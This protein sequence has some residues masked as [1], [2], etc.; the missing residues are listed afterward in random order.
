[1]MSQGCGPH[2]LSDFRRRLFPH[3]CL[4]SS[5]PSGFMSEPGIVEWP[6]TK[7]FQSS[8]KGANPVI[9]KAC[10][11]SCSI[12]T[13]RS[14]VERHPLNGASVRSTTP[15]L[16]GISNS[17]SSSFCLKGKNISIN[18][19]CSGVFLRRSAPKSI[20]L[21]EAGCE[22]YKGRDFAEAD[23]P[24]P[25]WLSFICFF[26]DQ[27][28]FVLGTVIR[29]DLCVVVNVVQQGPRAY[30]GDTGGPKTGCTG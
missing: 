21:R 3:P 12:V 16:P 26:V 23:R 22:P 30:G 6:G 24:V 11:A 9:P 2:S 18:S 13:Y 7:L 14:V 17:V 28:D 29:H 5:S 25:D 1:M 15:S 27:F 10:P 20:I 19:S 4:Y 8:S